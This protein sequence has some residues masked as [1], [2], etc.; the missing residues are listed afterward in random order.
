ML[1]SVSPDL[2]SKL[3][4]NLSNCLGFLPWGLTSI[5]HFSC[6]KL[7]SFKLHRPQLSHLHWWQ[8]CVPVDHIQTWLI[9]DSSFS[10]NSHEICLSLGSIHPLF[11]LWP[12][13]VISGFD[14]CG[15][16]LDPLDA[17]TLPLLESNRKEQ[18]ESFKKN[19]YKIMPL[20][21]SKFA[22]LFHS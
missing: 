8:S 14:Y 21:F 22:F 1:R 20:L 3:Q 15:G 7:N 16:F 19:V 5:S 12:E 10:H 11:L 9:L 6:S 18:S 13:F 2:S 17:S 4:I